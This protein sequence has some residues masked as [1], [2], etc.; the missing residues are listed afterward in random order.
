MTLFKGAPKAGAS[1]A[2]NR[3]GGRVQRI[4]L[5][6]PHVRVTVDCGFLL[7]ALVTRRSIEE[8]GLRDGSPITAHFTSTAP[9]LLRHGKP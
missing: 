4:V 7:V 5:A 8:M 6:G 2:F 1:A 3:L 9:H